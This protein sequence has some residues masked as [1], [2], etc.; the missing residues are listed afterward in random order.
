MSNL[1]QEGIVVVTQAVEADNKRDYRAAI[2]RYDRAV[3]IFNEAL[4]CALSE[5][6]LLFVACLFEFE[7]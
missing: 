1:L 3:S 4:I 2:D 5:F 6:V 7:C